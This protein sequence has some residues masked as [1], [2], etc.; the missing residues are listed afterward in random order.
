MA[1]CETMEAPLAHYD[2]SVRTSTV[3]AEGVATLL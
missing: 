1:T 2:E 3:T